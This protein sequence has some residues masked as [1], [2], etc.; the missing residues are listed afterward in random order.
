VIEAPR[1][2]W[3]SDISDIEKGLS[4]NVCTFP[5]YL[6]H[7]PPLHHPNKTP[8]LYACRKRGYTRK[9]EE[10]QELYVA[11]LCKTL[12]SY[13]PTHAM[14]YQMPQDCKTKKKATSD[15]I[16]K[17]ALTPLRTS[18]WYSTYRTPRPPNN[19]PLLPQP[20]LRRLTAPL[21][22]NR[23][24]LQAARHVIPSRRNEC[25]FAPQVLDFLL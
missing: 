4:I 16:H 19:N 6:P 10:T 24:A 8:S 17:S 1:T 5:Q 12:E 22:D 20:T 9:N 13:R 11:V 7:S 14:L 25:V 23:V 3:R 21:K 15:P 18:D 2:L